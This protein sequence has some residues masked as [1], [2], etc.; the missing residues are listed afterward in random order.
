MLNCRTF[1][2]LRL[3]VHRR[4]PSGPRETRQKPRHT[5]SVGPA[6]LLGPCRSDKRGESKAVLALE[7]ESMHAQVICTCTVSIPCQDPA[8]G[9][10]TQP[11]RKRVASESNVASPEQ[12]NAG[13]KTSRDDSSISAMMRSSSTG[14]TLGLQAQSSP[15][16]TQARLLSRMHMVTTHDFSLFIV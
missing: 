12:G 2:I 13:G 15:G 9:W 8:H 16:K 14:K 10:S 3:A 6:C 5:V 1:N 7:A 4:S 11:A